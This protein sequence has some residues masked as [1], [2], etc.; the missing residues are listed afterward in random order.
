[1]FYQCACRATER[2]YLSRPLMLEDDSETVASYYVDELRRAVPPFE[3]E[4]EMVRSDYEGRRLD[5]IS[6]TTQMS[7]AIVRQEERHRHRLVKENLVPLSR[8]RRLLTLARNDGYISPAA[9][10][11]IEIERERCSPKWGPYDGQITDPHLLDLLKQKF[12]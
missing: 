1:Y 5:D 4:T 8:V 2:L 11:R 6:N 3:I 10:R 9:L 12:G 7:V